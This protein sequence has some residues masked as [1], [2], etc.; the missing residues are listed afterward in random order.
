MSRIIF[1][2]SYIVVLPSFSKTATHKHP[3]MHLFVGANGC[4]IKVEKRELQSNIIMLDSNVEHVVE[5]RADCDFFLLI[6][7]TSAIAEKIIDKYLCDSRYYD[8]DANIAACEN[9]IKR[10]TDMESDYE[11]NKNGIITD[12]DEYNSKISAIEVKKEYLAKE[13]IAKKE[14]I[15]KSESNRKK[16]DNLMS[17]YDVTEEDR[18]ITKIDDTYIN[19]VMELNSLL[20]KVTEYNEYVQSLNNGDI[21]KICEELNHVKEYMIRIFYR[22]N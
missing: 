17:V 21:P 11:L 12:I 16:I 22:N 7:P 19:V 9:E 5:D 8:I 14:V 15:A 13:I 18:L 6:D 2:E 20:E 3:F 1:Q 10:L 4:K